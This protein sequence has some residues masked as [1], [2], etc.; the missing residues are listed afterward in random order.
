MLRFGDS[1]RLTSN[2]EHRLTLLTQERPDNVKSIHDLNQYLDTHAAR[3]CTESAADR[4]MR[5]LLLR[6]KLT[7]P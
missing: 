3:H 7:L 6:E 2:D 4:L 5:F 1:I